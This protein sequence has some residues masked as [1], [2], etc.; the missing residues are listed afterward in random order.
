[1]NDFYKV[2]HEG[3]LIK[4][5]HYSDNW[6]YNI[7]HSFYN[8]VIVVDIKGSYDYLQSIINENITISVNST[9]YEYIIEGI[10]LDMDNSPSPVGKVKV[11]SEKKFLNARR[12][13][14][15]L[16]NLGCNLKY[17]GED[18]GTFS[19]IT[20]LSLTGACLSTNVEMECSDKVTLN[21]VTSNNACLTLSGNIIWK[22]TSSNKIFYGV[23]F[24]N[25]KSDN[26]TILDELLSQLESIESSL[27]QNWRT[28]KQE[29]IKN[30]PLSLISL[31]VDDMKITRTYI[32]SI[33]ESL[34][35]SKIYEASNGNQAIQ[36]SLLYKPDIIT[37]DLSMP[38][39]DGFETLKIIRN[40]NS[41]ASVIVISAYID[42]EIRNALYSLD[43]KY[44]IS[45]PF[46]KAQ[47]IETINKILKEDLH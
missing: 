2:I 46:E 19:I 45:K 8:D 1:L 16:T 41:K 9:D 3:F 32:K 22:D 28:R 42:S 21:I 15:Y 5:K 6:Q 26:L 17:S 24:N 7:I 20:N 30:A 38:G 25:N 35:F 47:I 44:Y 27:V 10:V 11:I 13:C 31:I 23:V 39:I 14:R 4:T 34:G 36:Q 33:L 43:V 18:I 12:Y 40:S 29:T 37:L